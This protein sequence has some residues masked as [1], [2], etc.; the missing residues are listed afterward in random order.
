M[1]INCGVILEESPLPDVGRR[2][3]EEIH[4]AVASGKQSKA[5]S[6]R[7]RGERV[8]PLDSGPVM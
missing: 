8:R 4:V 2:I 3:F 5:G 6:R 7:R 1:D